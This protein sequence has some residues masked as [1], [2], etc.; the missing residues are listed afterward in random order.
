MDMFAKHEIITFSGSPQSPA[1]TKRISENP[2]KYKY[3]FR[4]VP[5]AGQTGVFV[6]EWLGQIHDELGLSKL[7]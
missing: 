1:Y 2:E 3:M 7:F 6:G 4:A 5:N